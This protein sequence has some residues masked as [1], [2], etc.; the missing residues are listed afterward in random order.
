MIE[1]QEIDVELVNI[2]KLLNESSSSI[3]TKYSCFGHKE[4]SQLYIMFDDYV[5]EELLLEW[6]KGFTRFSITYNGRLLL[7]RWYRWS[8]MPNNAEFVSN[9][10][11]EFK[12]TDAERSRLV[13]ELV[14]YTTEFMDNK[15]RDNNGSI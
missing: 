14:W 11:L 6:F 2:L 13:H 12:G 5:N 7:K 3:K 15:R 10:V 9:W 8:N 4:Y 1:Y